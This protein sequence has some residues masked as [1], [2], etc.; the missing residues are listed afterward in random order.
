MYR[1]IVMLFSILLLTG[2]TL[3]YN[4][5]FDGNKII[6]NINGTVTTKELD[7]KDDETG[8]NIYRSYLYNELRVFQNKDDIYEKNVTTNG[9]IINFEFHYTYQDNYANSRIV[10]T[11]FNQPNI[12]ETD[13]LYY[14]N[15][16]GKFNCLFSDKVTINMTSEYVVLEDNADKVKNNVYTWVIDSEDDVDI[17]IT[18][19][20]SIKENKDNK[21]GVSTFKIIGLIVLII[22][23]AVTFV[24]YKNHNKNKD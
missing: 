2:C 15:L 3:N 24:L 17:S 14:I 18:V 10:K 19:S 11:C 4:L 5:E 6:E 12:I 1:K 20:K 21:R 8:E 16:K 23:S 9:D 7:S 13:D 22:L